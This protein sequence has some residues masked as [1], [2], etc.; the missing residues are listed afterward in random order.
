MDENV[1]EYEASDEPAAVRMFA[2][3]FLNEFLECRDPFSEFTG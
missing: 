1:K 3:F 2:L